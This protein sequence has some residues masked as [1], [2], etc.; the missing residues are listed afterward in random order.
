MISGIRFTMRRV[1]NVY[2]I[3]LI[4]GSVVTIFTH[5]I[6]IVKDDGIIFDKSIMLNDSEITELLFVLFLFALIYFPAVNIY[7]I[8]KKKG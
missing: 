2:G 7:W 1:L 6:R 5:P 8:R 4:L 3:L